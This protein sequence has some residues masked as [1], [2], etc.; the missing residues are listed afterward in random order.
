[1]AN[2]SL[3]YGAIDPQISFPETPGTIGL[4]YI[5]DGRFFIKMHQK[6]I[7]G[8]IEDI[9]IPTSDDLLSIFAKILLNQ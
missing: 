5:K 8:E 2:I 7:Y 3:N 4:L 6:S 1:M 9:E